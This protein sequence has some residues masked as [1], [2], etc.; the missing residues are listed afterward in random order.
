MREAF[1]V[2]P[3]RAVDICT[4]LYIFRIYGILPPIDRHP[5]QGMYLSG[6]TIIH[7]R[8]KHDSILQI[9]AVVCIYGFYGAYNCSGLVR[10]VSG[11]SDV[12]VN[13]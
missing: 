6:Y 3:Y 5:V 11:F 8:L 13:T 10:Q 1:W 2:L 7:R 9:L 4:Q 12:S